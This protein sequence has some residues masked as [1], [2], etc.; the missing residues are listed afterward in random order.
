M[1]HIL[2]FPM[3]ECPSLP[4]LSA[5][6]ESKINQRNMLRRTLCS[7]C[8]GCNQNQPGGNNAAQIQQFKKPNAVVMSSTPSWEIERILSPDRFCC[9]LLHKVSWKRAVFSGYSRNRVSKWTGSFVSLTK[10]VQRVFS[11]LF[12]LTRTDTPI[13]LMEGNN[14]HVSFPWNAAITVKCPREYSP[15]GGNLWLHL[16]QDAHFMSAG[17]WGSALLWMFPRK[18]G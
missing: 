11:S 5:L 6:P 13:A 12:L 18:R 15:D 1:V 14:T 2:T 8:A 17:G 7:Q 4:V 10:F 16:C 9:R 3:G